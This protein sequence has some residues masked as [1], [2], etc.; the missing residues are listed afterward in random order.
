MTKLSHLM[1]RKTFKCLFKRYYKKMATDLPMILAQLKLAKR[2]QFHLH[3][4]S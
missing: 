3:S 2:E 1:N 4:R